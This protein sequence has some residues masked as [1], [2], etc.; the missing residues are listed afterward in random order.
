[1]SEYKLNPEQRGRAAGLLA[2]VVDDED[3]VERLVYEVIWLR[4]HVE[5]MGKDLDALE[6]ALEAAVR[7]KA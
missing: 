7:A 2:A 3:R 6:E 4:D 5:E 1:M